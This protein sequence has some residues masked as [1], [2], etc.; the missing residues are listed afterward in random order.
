MNKSEYKC[1]LKSF[2]FMA[3]IL[4]GLISC[5]NSLEPALQS[6]IDLIAAKFVPDHRIGICD[7]K[8]KSTGKTI[9]LKG[10]TTDDAAKNAILKALDNQNKLLI[11]SVITLPDT[12]INKRYLG[13]VTLSVINLRKEPDHAS[14]LV[15]QARLGTPVIILKEHNSWLLIQTPDNYISWT[16]KSSI[17]SMDRPEMVSWKNARRVIYLE[18]TGWL[19][20]TTTVNSGVVGDLVAGSVM[21]KTLDFNGFVKVALPDGRNGYILKQK[22]MDFTEWKNNIKCTD[23]KI[24]NVA[25]TFLGLPYLW[26]GSSTKGVDC[27]GFVQTVYFLN[28]LILQRDA[29]LQALHGTLVD[30]SNGYSNLKSG[31]LLFFGSKENGKN[32]VTHVAIYIGHN[33]YINSSSRVLIN[34]LDSTKGNYVSYRMTS[35]LSA[36]RIIG[37]QGDPGIVEISKHPWY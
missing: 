29:S 28:G 17:V 13:L 9:V 20:D 23:E 30:I 6:E 22:V 16:E 4:I 5:Q 3:G 35:L 32:H 25:K 24:C 21:V 12:T 33:D 15:S 8:L 11:D 27:S 36:K 7:I 1:F 14:E 2:G 10:E 37:T 18:N 19:Y 34:S 31:D 26:G